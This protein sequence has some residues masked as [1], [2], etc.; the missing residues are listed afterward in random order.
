M[1]FI[2]STHLAYAVDG[3]GDGRIDLRNSLPDALHSAANYLK[4]A[5]WRV[6]EDWG[7]EVKLPA[8]FDLSQADLDRQK[9]LNSWSFLGLRRPDGSLLPDSYQNASLIMPQGVDG[10]AFLVTNNYRVILRWNRSINYALAVGHLADR[11]SGGP[12]LST[13]LLADNRRL[14]REQLETLQKHLATLGYDPGPA[15]GV[16]GT[17]TRNAIRAFQSAAGLPADGHPSLDL[18]ERLHGAL[19]APE[20]VPPMPESAGPVS[21]AGSA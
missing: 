8:G 19:P 11:L 3:D 1:Q 14:T 7:M 12:P 13:G 20:S 4:R 15:D 10:P 9:P 17:R 5:G 21:A 18:L 6:D 16:P 2:P